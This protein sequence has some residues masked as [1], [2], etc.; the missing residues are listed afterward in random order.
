MNWQDRA[1]GWQMTPTPGGWTLTRPVPLGTLLEF[2]VRRD[3]GVEE[4]DVH[5]GRALAHQHVV[6]GDATVPFEV[7]G[8]QNGQGGARPSTRP[9]R[10]VAFTLWSPELH[11]DREVLV[12][13]PP[14]YPAGGPYP[15][16]YL[17]DGQNMFD[18]ATAF[19]GV[20][21][22]ADR[23]ADTLARGGREVI[24]VAVPCGPRR[25]QLYTPFRSRV[26]A[27]A[28]LAD[29]YLAF[30]TGTLK[31]HV[32]R[33]YR[34]RPERPFT[35]V[36]GSSFGGLISLYAAFTHADTYGAAGVFSPSL[37]VGDHEVWPW[38]AT[39]ARGADRVYVDMGTHEGD[40]VDASR[41]LVRHALALADTLS[42]KGSRVRAQVGE[43]HWH[44]EVAWAERF[45]AFLRFFLETC[46]A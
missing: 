18:E 40:D 10:T 5:G 13:L 35:G 37:W 8:W 28:P 29:A 11:E 4:G 24:L 41:M 34:T 15:V 16:L 3:D 7:T 12:H 46:R 43:G 1:D 25:S 21:W 44:D 27:Y 14:S 2:K 17:H 26:N 23:A 6:T 38:L 36:A 33:T 31:A 20:T 30:L 32:D 19:S 42:D 9:A 45:P 22:R 39:R